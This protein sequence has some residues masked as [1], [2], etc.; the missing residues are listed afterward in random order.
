MNIKY[1]NIF[2]TSIIELFIECS[3]IFID[4]QGNDT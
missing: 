3:L 1:F 2:E 4:T